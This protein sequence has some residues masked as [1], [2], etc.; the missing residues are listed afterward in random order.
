LKILHEENKFFERE[1]QKKGK[2]IAELEADLTRVRAERASALDV[3]SK[4]GLTSSEWLLRTGLAERKVVKQRAAFKKLGAKYSERGKKLVD[5]RAWAIFNEETQ[6]IRQDL[7]YQDVAE[8]FQQ[9]A[10]DQLRR[11]G[12]L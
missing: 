9:I 3:K 4:E 8:R 1:L 7:P 10:R 2:R 6:G 5:E 11:E 12:K